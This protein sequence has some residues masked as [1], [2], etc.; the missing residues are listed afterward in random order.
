MDYNSAVKILESL[1]K[2]GSKPGL[3]RIS[4]LMEMAGNPHK[5][6]RFIHVAG[7][8]GKGSVCYMLESILRHQ[9]YKTGLYISPH[10]IDYRERISINGKNISKKSFSDLVEI[11]YKLASDD[12]FK[13]DDITEFEL[14]T[15][16]AFK[17]F[18][19]N[20]CDIVILETGMGG[21]FDAT[22]IIENPVCSV[23]TSI[24][25]DHTNILG[26]NLE[27]IALEKCGIIKQNSKCVVSDEQ[28][29]IVYKIIRDVSSSRNS[30]FIPAKNSDIKKIT[31]NL[32]G[33]SFDYNGVQVKTKILG[34]YQITNMSC[35]LKVIESIKNEFNVSVESIKN[36][37]KN[38]KI[39]CRLEIINNSPL[40]IV[41]V[42]H[43]PAGTKVLFD[44]V[45]NNLL[46]RKILGITSMLRDKN[47][48]K[49]FGNILKIFDKTYIFGIKNSR[50]ETLNNLMESARKFSKEVV[51]CKTFSEAFLLAQEN[52]QP[53]SAIVIFG[54]F[55]VAKEIKKF[56]I[57]L[58]NIF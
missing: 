19:E 39:P 18:N 37:L 14:I 50:A 52:S 53:D 21:K 55:F 33:T 31:S 16:M 23:I 47:Y 30:D 2:F 4:K 38:V 44:F 45:K 24:S 34:E 8:N 36:G 13:D 17:F 20:N 26:D 58:D 9:G 11:L 54:S 49:S 40:I 6:T 27:K 41:D 7:T 43:N 10:I 32:Y 25:L 22:N 1:Q 48:E 56:K 12:C 5:N 51:A 15:A 28:N 29:G 42:A 3:E 57:M 46:G 35:A